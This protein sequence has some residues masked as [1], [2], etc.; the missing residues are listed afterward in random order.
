MLYSLGRVTGT[1]VQD[2]PVSRPRYSRYGNNMGYE[3]RSSS[4]GSVVV[5]VLYVGHACVGHVGTGT[6]FPYYV[7]FEN[8]A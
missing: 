6:Y 7:K 2:L 5:L 4:T 1:V 3:L 8:I